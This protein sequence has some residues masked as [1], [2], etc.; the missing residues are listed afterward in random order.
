M[1]MYAGEC[2]NE[3]K[4]MQSERTGRYCRSIRRRRPELSHQ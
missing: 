2:R 1:Q 4:K 3:K